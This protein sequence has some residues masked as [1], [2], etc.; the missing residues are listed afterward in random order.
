MLPGDIA[1]DIAVTTWT[2]YVHVSAGIMAILSEVPRT[3]GLD[4]VVF[5]PITS[6]SLF[7]NHDK[8]RICLF[9]DTA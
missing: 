4:V 9:S 8:F 6:N 1:N 5:F 3:N 7:T 2:F